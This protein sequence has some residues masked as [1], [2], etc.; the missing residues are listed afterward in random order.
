MRCQ[1]CRVRLL[2]SRL[3]S[4]IR[5][6]QT[7]M[8][9]SR[10][11]KENADDDDGVV[12][13]P[14]ET[15][16]TNDGSMSGDDDTASADASDSSSCDTDRPQCSICLDYLDAPRQTIGGDDTDAAE[17]PEVPSTTTG[18]AS[19]IVVYKTNAKDC[20]HMFHSDCIVEWL[21]KHSTCPCCRRPVF[22]GEDNEEE[23]EIEEQGQP[24]E[25]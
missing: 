13:V 24:Q 1:H 2:P 11:N 21:M 4:S 22:H 19:G 3:V 5:H 10:V 14:A 18:E 9:Q 7:V 17:D 25:P 16:K 12:V 8:P 23:N 6:L 20:D 15:N